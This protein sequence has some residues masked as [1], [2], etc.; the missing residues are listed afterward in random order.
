MKE[1]KNDP[2]LEM[3]IFETNELIKQLENMIIEIDK[4]EN[5]TK[6]DINEIFRIMHSIKGSSAMMEFNNISNLAHNVEELFHYIRE[7]EPIIDNHSEL[8]DIVL[9]SIDFLVTEVQ[10]ISKDEKDIQ[11]SS[12]LIKKI[13]N[14]LNDIKEN[15]LKKNGFSVVI[16]FEEGCQMENMRA[17][18]IINELKKSADIIGYYPADIED[19]NSIDSIRENG[20]KINFYINQDKENTKNLINSF[21][22]IK[23]SNIKVLQDEEFEKKEALNSINKQNNINNKQFVKNLNQNVISVNLQKL[24]TLM[25][26]VGE[27][28]ISESMVINN[29]EVTK[30]QIDNFEKASRQLVKV[31][32]DIQDI[33]MSLRM[34]PV[35]FAFSP[36]NRIVRDMGKK[37]NKKINLNIVGQETEVDK[38]IIEHLNDPLIH[39]VR[40]AIDHGLESQEERLKKGKD[41]VGTI[42]LEAKNIGSDVA[43]SI[44]DDGRGLDRK[45]IEEKALKNG[46]IEEI[47]ESLSDKEVYSYIMLPGFSTTDTISE[48]S[49]RG[50]GMDIVS[51]NIQKVGGKVIINSEKGKGTEILIK[52]PLTLAIMDGMIVRIGK[53][54]FVI[55]INYIRRSFIPNEKDII[56]DS[57]NNYEMMLV[58][59]ECYPLIRLDNIFDIKS[60]KEKITDGIIILVENEFGGVC[61]WTDSLE[62]KQQI[63]VKSL[64]H[65]IKKQVEIAG[66]TLLGDGSISLILDIENIISEKGGDKS[67]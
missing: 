57:V 67:D 61:L 27:L 31:T 23:S 24:D 34:I 20:F 26:L 30:L 47:D 19:S 59:G 28:V 21:P 17:F 25:N 63:V 51:K 7:N 65:Y 56:H 40:N 29:P 22:F 39:L 45:R 43:I 62:G 66:C 49:G 15:R 8:C 64:P 5:F 41:P 36:V 13:N 52:I 44:R 48:Y 9:E 53:S 32:K 12:A 3:F 14:F 11:D 58:R 46:L 18:F 1:N 6:E 35:S 42:T 33:V 55:P 54:R 4:N 16:Y 2:L 60:D 10:N 37:M 50:V 38:N